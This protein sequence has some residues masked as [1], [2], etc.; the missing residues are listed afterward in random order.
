VNEVCASSGTLSLLEKCA[1]KH[2]FVREGVRSLSDLIQS[3]ARV[4]ERENN[5]IFFQAVPAQSELPPLPPGAFIMVRKVF[6]PPSSG[7]QFEFGSALTVPAPTISS[8]SPAAELNSSADLRS[9]LTGEIQ[10]IFSPAS[11]G[12]NLHAGGQSSLQGGSVSASASASAST[13]TKSD[14]EIALDLQRRIDAGEDL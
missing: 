2:P 12:N 9:K 6:Q 11:L 10:T 7:F 13:G 1:R 5:M 3:G 8:T 14:Y 4:A